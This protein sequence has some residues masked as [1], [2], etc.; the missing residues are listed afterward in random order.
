VHCAHGPKSAGPFQADGPITR[1]TGEGERARPWPLGGGAD[2]ADGAHKGRR[3]EAMGM[4]KAVAAA[5]S[6]PVCAVQTRTLTSGPH[7]GWDFQ[8]SKNRPKATNS[9][10]TLSLAP[11]FL[12]FCMRLD[13]SILKNFINCTDFKFPI[14]IMLKILEQIQI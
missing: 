13:W 4:G 12:N 8:N 11:K 9:K 14:E 1:K 10:W 2:K 6:K 7:P 5:V 3:G